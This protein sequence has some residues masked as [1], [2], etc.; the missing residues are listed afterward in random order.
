MLYITVA[1][2]FFRLVKNKMKHLH[3]TFN[4]KSQQHH[5]STKY[6]N[7]LRVLQI[8]NITTTILK[9]RCI[10]VHQMTKEM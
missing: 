7:N 1:L 10:M 5:F 9:L 3:L 8:R 4:T 6:S 2:F